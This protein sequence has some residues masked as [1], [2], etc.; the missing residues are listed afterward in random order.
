M[1]SDRPPLPPKAWIPN[2]V[3]AANIA[4][5]FTSMLVAAEGRFELAVYMLL[6]CI[7]LDM[8]DG[9]LARGLKATSELGR[10]LD[11]FCDLISFGAAP[12]FLLYRAT[13]SKLGWVGGAAAVLYL[14]AGLYR[15]ARF[16]LSSDPHAKARRTLGVPIPIGAGYLMATVLMRDH[17]RPS[18]AAAVALAMAVSMVSRWRLPDLKGKGLVSALLLV[19]ILNYLAV[20]ARPGWPTILWWNFWNLLIVLAA[21]REDRRL[22]GESA[23]AEP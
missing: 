18:W 15:L 9:R 20:I 17:L 4:V 21:W 1:P 7:F 13:L 8:G 11:S 5:G 16:N 10:E 2:L 23:P 12:A 22:P 3:T 14:L 6:A 19:G